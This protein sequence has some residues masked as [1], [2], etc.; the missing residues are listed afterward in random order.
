MVNYKFQ[1]QARSAKRRARVTLPSQGLTINQIVAK[2][3]RGIA[4]DVI[5]R[6]AVYMDQ[7]D[8]DMEKLQRMDFSE[9]AAMAADLSAQAQEYKQ[10]LEANER[11]KQAKKAQ[12]AAG[13]PAP[14]AQGGAPQGA[15]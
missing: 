4:V 15:T 11:A 1:L 10:R 8:Y 9:Q 3:V 14:G 13:T 12:A 7:S 2:Y 5:Q 6:Q